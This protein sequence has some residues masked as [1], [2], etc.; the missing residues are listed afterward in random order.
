M[1]YALIDFIF[2][3]ET[4]KKKQP[5]IIMIAKS[6]NFTYSKNKNDL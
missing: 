2:I 6:S 1:D 4:D 3:L 5:K